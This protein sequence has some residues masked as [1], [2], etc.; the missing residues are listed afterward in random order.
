MSTAVDDGKC[1]CGET[2]SDEIRRNVTIRW[3]EHSDM[4][5][6]SEPSKHLYQFTGHRCN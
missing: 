2:Y 3:D 4:G 1:N 5:K 6:N